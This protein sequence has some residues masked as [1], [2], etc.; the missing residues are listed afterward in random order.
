MIGFLAA[1]ALLKVGAKT[2]E[3][4]SINTAF[5]HKKET[6]ER[7]MIVKALLPQPYEQPIKASATR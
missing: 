5:N 7:F 2:T 1:P 4:H 3:Q 6:L